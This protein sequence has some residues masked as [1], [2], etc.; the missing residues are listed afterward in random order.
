VGQ[1]EYDI[2]KIETRGKRKLSRKRKFEGEGSS[3]ISEAHPAAVLASH[4]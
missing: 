4:N 3:L 2:S 1:R